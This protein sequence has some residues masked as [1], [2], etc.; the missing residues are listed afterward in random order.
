MLDHSSSPPSAFAY[1][2]THT[3]TCSVSTSHGHRR[4]PRFMPGL[5]LILSVLLIGLLL[6]LLNGASS[7][8]A[9]DRLLELVDLK[10]AS[11]NSA[12][13]S[14]DLADP[15]KFPFS[16]T[17]KWTGYLEFLGKP[18]TERSLGQPDLF[19]PL[20]QDKNDMTFFNLRGQLQFDNTDVS[21]YNIGLGH[22][23]MFQEWILGGY[24]YFDHRNTQLNNA[25]RQFTGGLELMSVDWAFRMNGYLPENKT[26]TDISGANIS[27]IRPGDQIK[28]QI[29][30]IVQEKALPGLDGEVGYLLPIPWNAYTQVFDETR[31]YAGGYHFLGED[32]F[33]SVTGPRGRVEWRAYDL[34]VLGPGSRFMM[35]VEAQW[36]EPRGSQAFGLFSLRI[37]FDVFADNSERRKLTGLDRRMLQPVIRDVDVVT[38]EVG[39]TEIVP[40]LN[41]AGKAYQRAEDLTLE[42]YNAMTPDGT[43]IARIIQGQGAIVEDGSFRSPGENETAANAGKELKVGYQSRWLGAGTVGYLPNGSPFTLKGGCNADNAVVSMN[44]GSHLN[45]MIVDATGCLKGINIT[46]GGNHYVSNSITSGA[47]E[48]GMYL[49]NSSLFADTLMIT[50]N[51]SPEVLESVLEDEDLDIVVGGLY[52]ENSDVTFTGGTTT[53]SNNMGNG[54]TAVAGS[55]VT[56]AGGTTTISRNEIDGIYAWGSTVTFAGGTTTISHNQDDGMD[57]QKGEGEEAVASAVEFY[58]GT[59]TISHN[60][61]DGIDVDGSTVAFT[62]GTTTIEHNVDDGIDA[63]WSNVNFTGGTTMIEYNDRD[64]ID[65]VESTLTFGGGTTT[66]RENRRD[67]IKAERGEEAE[68][69]GS[70]VVFTGGTTT[71]SDNEDDGIYTWDSTVRFEGGMTTIS[72]NHEDGIHAEGES[73][74]VFTGGTTTI[75]GNGEEGEDS[76]ERNGIY[77][78]DSTVEFTGGT[79]TIEDND[80]DGIHADSGSLVKFKSGTTTISNNKG[81]G[82]TAGAGSI[83]AFTGG[84]T[85]IRNNEEYGAV[86]RL[87]GDIKFLSGEH[88][89]DG[90][91][92]GPYGCDGG[93]ITDLS[94]PICS[95]PTF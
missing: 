83:V 24:G 22:R 39:V 65:A 19:L 60:Q 70:S 23:H 47:S 30:G 68:A 14:M 13:F 85:T 59:T 31:V 63:E 16:S 69:V 76:D 93:N 73:T 20:L 21:E 75:R 88:L 52:A 15:N 25:Y 89:I 64:G 27:V 79:T 17:G 10:V 94:G 28:V 40:A 81:N 8:W 90:N 48:Q 32:N 3:N 34:P 72:G 58:A 43:V 61:R 78:W 92:L 56:F 62:G 54:M 7:S 45:G 50:D 95:F 6:T 91:R 53:I 38:S 87:F 29:D 71:I 80:G 37:P 86:A 67:G 55:T 77:A 11:A 12:E 26:T 41:P 51:V 33:D 74:V 49:Q 9:K 42:E 4:R 84:M 66:I 2:L 44:S 82:M 5:G 36:D 1:S 18:G 46:G 57:V 35:G